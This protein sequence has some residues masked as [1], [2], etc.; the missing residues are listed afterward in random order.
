MPGATQPTARA[1]QQT[2]TTLTVRWK[3]QP[4]VERY[5]LQ[6]ARDQGFSDIVFDQ[7]VSGRQHSASLPSGNY[8]WRV[9]PAVGETG[10]YSN[11]QLVEV[12]ES[13]AVADEKVVTITKPDSGWRTATGEVPRV[14]P[15]RLRDGRGLD[16]VVV[17]TDG[18]V[19]AIDGTNGVAIWTARFNPA[20]RR[21]EASTAK[22]PLFAPLGLS[23]QDGKS[24]VVV[25]YEGGLRAIRGESGTELWR[26]T[27]PGRATGG[28]VADLDGDGKLE[29]VAVTADP[30]TLVILSGEGGRVMASA[31]LD[32]PALGAPAFLDS[33]EGRGVVLG[34]E[35]GTVE[36]R[37]KGGELVRS[38]KLDTQVTTAPLVV[39]TAR[40]LL[41]VIGVEQGL[42]ALTASDLKQ[43]GQINTGD[44]SP[45]GSMTAADLDGDGTSEVVMVTRGGR[46]ALIG[47]SDGKIRWVSEGA[48]DADSVALADLD[49]D[50][51]LDVIAAAGPAFAYGFSGVDGS[52]IWRVEEE[53]GR[54]PPTQGAS[55]WPRSLVIALSQTGGA[56]LVGGD[57]SRTGLQAVE[58]PKGAVKTAE[59]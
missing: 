17:N 4:G 44:D 57:P 38:V 48:K 43:L 10:E 16:L 54:R 41:V 55:T 34:L 35:G 53:S 3:G 13:P 50:G 27:F 11:A 42:S 19:Y 21:G 30:A 51:V 39:N 7:A 49:G 1:Q 26:A 9:A 15:V 45:R 56:F 52:L 8:F 14:V 24:N 18:A 25:A 33:A 58:L 59:R 37:G 2:A 47:T 29:V 22:G 32:A 31:R 40:A 46:V 12:T 28:M 5:R 6:I 36:V 23:A 20:A